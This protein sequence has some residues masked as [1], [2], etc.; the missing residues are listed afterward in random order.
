VPAHLKGIAHDT[1]VLGFGERRFVISIYHHD[2]HIASDSPPIDMGSADPGVY[3]L[4]IK[5]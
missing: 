5:R 1:I 2:H 4:A 3:T